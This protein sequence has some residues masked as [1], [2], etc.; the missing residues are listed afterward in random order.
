MESERIRDERRRKA[1]LALLTGF[2]MTGCTGGQVSDNN[3]PADAA[4]LRNGSG[5]DAELA[6][7]AR[8]LK[9]EEVKYMVSSSGTGSTTPS[10]KALSIYSAITS[11]MT[12][13]AVGDLVSPVLQE[14]GVEV[15]H[16]SR[17]IY[18][19][20]GANT[21]FWVEFNGAPGSGISS[22]KSGLQAKSQ[23]RRYPNG[24]IEILPVTN[25]PDER[26]AGKLTGKVGE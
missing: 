24:D 15:G 7:P 3:R 11:G 10:E 23:W 13:A 20:I 2:V 6:F 1:Y 9:T 26:V 18:Y 5:R 17:R 14:S 12:E 8:R 22:H 19:R 25:G 16:E 4:A 21:Q